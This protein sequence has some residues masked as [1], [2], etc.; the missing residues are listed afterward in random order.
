MTTPYLLS[1]TATLKPV[2]AI[3]SDVYDDGD[4]RGRG[5]HRTNPL[6]IRQ[7]VGK[8][9]PNTRDLPP[10][11]WTYGRRDRYD[12]EGVRE[13]IGTWKTHRPNPEE[14][15]GRDFVRLNK[16]AADAG[17][18]TAKHTATFRQVNDI[19]LK[20]GE[21]A[22]DRGGYVVYDSLDQHTF[23]RPTNR[24]TTPISLVLTNTYQRQWIEDRRQLSNEEHVESRAIQQAGK[25]GKFK[26]SQHTRASLGHQKVRAPPPASP[27][28]LKRFTEVES[29]VQLPKGARPT[30]RTERITTSVRTS[31]APASYSSLTSPLAFSSSSSS[32]VQHNGHGSD[33]GYST[34]SSSHYE[35]GA[36][37]AHHHVQEES[38]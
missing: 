10:E 21:A 5:K 1:Q 28:K 29:R 16:A 12:P 23:G 8:V 7:P 25:W 32:A 27:F 22:T 18:T 4:Y 6:L 24:P 31:T 26:Q 11:E 35:E 3:G 36:H 13:V 19:R 37:S 17:A 20:Q 30:G 15:P 2:R 34:Q 9:R 14:M 38:F 33:Y